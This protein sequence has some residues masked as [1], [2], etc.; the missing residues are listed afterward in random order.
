MWRQPGVGSK[1]VNFANSS[2]ST[3]T[4]RNIASM[5]III[6]KRTIHGISHMV[7]KSVL[8][9]RAILANSTGSTSLKEA[10]HRKAKSY[11]QLA[12]PTDTQ[13]VIMKLLSESTPKQMQNKRCVREVEPSAGNNRQKIKQK[14]IMRRQLLA[15]LSGYKQSW[16]TTRAR[17]RYLWLRFNFKP[18]YKTIPLLS[19]LG[20]YLSVMLISPVVLAGSLSEGFPTADNYPNGTLVSIRN[21]VPT[22]VELANLN[23][24]DYLLGTVESEGDSLLTISGS[25]STV[26]VATS[27]DVQAFV[28]DVN[29]EVKKGDFVGSSWISGIGMKAD[30]DSQ[31]KLLGIALQ[32]FSDV[33]DSA[34]KF[35]NIETPTG[36]VSAKVAKIAIRLFDRE[37]GPALNQQTSAL[38]NFASKITGKEVAFARIFAALALFV[39]SLIISGVFLSNAIRGSFISLGRNPL[40]SSSIFAS[41]MQVSG[42]S[43]SLVL[44]GALI[45]YLVLIL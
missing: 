38:E 9:L 12:L 23:N 19:I 25:N 6:Y 29:G 39:V 30:K 20:L 16:A 3:K 7:Y 10:L 26:Y 42:V 41:L 22:S 31:Q 15:K 11:P 1:G 4:S 34:V 5:I 32:S 18:G 2:Q 37:I 24:N 43:I 21:T 27:G 35:A 14:N 8:K 45:A 44:I 13:Y 28:S 40:A 33:A 17:G 36:E